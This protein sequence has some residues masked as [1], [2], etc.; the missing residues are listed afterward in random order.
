MAYL[1]GRGQGC[2]CVPS[3]WVALSS[4]RDPPPVFSASLA[5]PRGLSMLSPE[6]ENPNPPGTSTVNARHSHHP[7]P[8]SFRPPLLR[9]PHG[10]CG[11]P[12]CSASASGFRTHLFQKGNER[13]AKGERKEDVFSVSRCIW[14]TP[15]CALFKNSLFIYYWLKGVLSFQT[16]KYTHTN[17]KSDC[18]RKKVQRKD[19]NKD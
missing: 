12:L 8:P 3:P 18:L 10:S 5:C 13:R 19:K 1:Q 15:K 17:L 7:L 11:S 9:T 4:W 14:K 16:V 6:H 2:P